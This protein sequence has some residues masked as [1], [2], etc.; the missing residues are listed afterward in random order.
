V[1][2][3]ALPKPPRTWPPALERR[4]AVPGLVL[5]FIAY[6]FLVNG[7]LICFF[8]VPALLWRFMGGGLAIAA[9]GF[10][11]WL[12]ARAR[13][14]NVAR[15]LRAGD[16]TVG[17]VTKIEPGK[18][19]RVHYEYSVNGQA[20]AGVLPEDPPYDFEENTDAAVLFDP[21]SP[22]KSLLLSKHNVESICETWKI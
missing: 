3:P 6:V 13:S 16:W 21:E 2:L 4:L 7:L 18:R 17:R 1:N 12:V 19:R 14:V 9:V 22:A 10:A 20:L 8:A 11:I 15:L 5:V